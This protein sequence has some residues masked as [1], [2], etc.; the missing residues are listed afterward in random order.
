MKWKFDEVNGKVVLRNDWRLRWDRMLT[1]P[2]FVAGFFCAVGHHMYVMDSRG[3]EEYIEFCRE[4][5]MDLHWGV[6]LTISLA[7]YF[8][9][10]SMYRKERAMHEKNYAE[11][12]KKTIGKGVEHE[13]A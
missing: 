13:Q 2:S 12:R 9:Y 7:C 1:L 11:Y 10:R 8:A 6:G 5:W 4:Y 3:L